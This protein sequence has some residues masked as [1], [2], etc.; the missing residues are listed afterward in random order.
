M[1]PIVREL[2]ELP[3]SVNN[4]QQQGSASYLLHA[5]ISANSAQAAIPERAA[6][7]RQQTELSARCCFSDEAYR[8]CSW[9]PNLGLPR[10]FVLGHLFLPKAGV[11][12]LIL[13]FE[14]TTPMCAGG[15]N[16]G[17]GM[18]TI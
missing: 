7:E 3:R 4:V 10:Q 1:I 2:S 6:G 8:S 15:H 5:A 12:L 14:C 16:I 13:F 11:S 9:M 17:I 18:Q